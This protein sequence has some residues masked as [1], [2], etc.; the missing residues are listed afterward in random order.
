MANPP[1]FSHGFPMVCQSNMKGFLRWKTAQTYPKRSSATRT[2]ERVGPENPS[3]WPRTAMAGRWV[4]YW[5][6]IL[7]YRFD[8]WYNM[9]KFLLKNGVWKI[10]E[11]FWV[12]FQI[13]RCRLMYNQLSRL[14]HPW[15]VEISLV[16]GV[17]CTQGC[18][19]YIYIYLLHMYI[20][21]YIWV[22]AKI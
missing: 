13:F 8:R 2:W 12:P 17:T 16:V 5:V 11:P 19:Q 18:L 22:T 20:Y 7:W 21:T 10:Y 15:E 9:I 1:G 14:W 3:P 4:S 6:V